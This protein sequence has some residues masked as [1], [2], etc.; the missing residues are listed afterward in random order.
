MPPPA[1]PDVL[2]TPYAA[3]SQKGGTLIAEDVSSVEEQLRRLSDPDQDRPC[4]CGNCGCDR[5]HV[6]DQRSRKVEG[7]PFGELAFWRFRCAVC[8]AVWMILAGFV[9]RH[10]HQTWE[11]VQGAVEQAKA[12]GKTGTA[13]AARVCARTV[14][15]WVRRLCC[16]A[17]VVSQALVAAEVVLAVGATRGELA[18]S[19]VAAGCVEA[20]R[21]LASVAVWLHRLVPGLRLL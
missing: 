13:K 6:H 3:K 5:L 10:L 8:R 18:D 20:R 16:S 7:A 15:R 11:G 1:A 2:T 17:V 19:L 4:R 14:G 9:A 21:K 12:V